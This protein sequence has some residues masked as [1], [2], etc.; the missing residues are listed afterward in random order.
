MAA[1]DPTANY[2]SLYLN[3]SFHEVDFASDVTV[4]L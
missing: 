3:N 2:S 1:I 4:T